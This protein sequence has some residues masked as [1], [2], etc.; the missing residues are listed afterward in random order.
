[1]LLA[2][3][4]R[5]G[6]TTWRLV[7]Y[8]RERDVAEALGVRPPCRGGWAG[9]DGVCGAVDGVRSDPSGVEAYQ[10]LPASADRAAPSGRSAGSTPAVEVTRRCGSD[11]AEDFDAGLGA[12][13]VGAG[14]VELVAFRVSP[15]PSGHSP[16]RMFKVMIRI[17]PGSQAALRTVT[18]GT[19]LAYDRARFAK[20]NIYSLSDGEPAVRFVGCRDRSAVFNGGILTTGPRTVRLEIIHDDRHLPVT[21]RAYDG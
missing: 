13:T 12:R 14:P 2:R 18:A 15:V 8:A 16:A 11:Y 7:Y 10:T 5:E 17:A 9:H 6:T 3:C 4:P 1:M 19:S 21:V 20:D